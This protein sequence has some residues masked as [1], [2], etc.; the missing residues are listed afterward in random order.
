MRIRKSFYTSLVITA[1]FSAVGLSLESPV[2]TNPL[3]LGTV[4][5]TAYKSGLVPSINPIDT[6]G[7]QVVTGNVVGGMYFRGVV[8]YRGVTDFSAPA[9][10]LSHTSA[11]IDPFLRNSAASADLSRPGGGIT[12]FYSPSWTVSTTAGGTNAT[13]TPQAV[14]NIPI[15]S[16][17]GV[18]PQGQSVYNQAGYIP[19]MSSRPLSMSRAEMEK[20]L[21]ADAVKYPLGAEPVSEA[22]SQRQFWQQLKIPI[23]RRQETP[24]NPDG[25]SKQSEPNVGALLNFKTE[26]IKPQDTQPADNN[27]IT[28]QQPDVYEQMKT[29][30]ENPLTNTKGMIEKTGL[31]AKGL[32]ESN[33]QSA[34][35]TS[36]SGPP[37]IGQVGYGG[38]YKSFAAFSDDKFNQY[39]SSA[40]SY[41][42][43]GRYYRAADAYTMAAV[44]KPKDPLGYAGKSQALFA[45]GEYMSSSLFLARALEIFPDYAKAKIDLV[46]M[47]GDKDTIENR[48]LEAREWR[49]RSQS[50]ELEFLLSYVYCQ[51]DR[52]EFARQMIESATKK[53]PDSPAVA[54][55]KKAVDERIAKQ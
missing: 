19:Q 29:Q 6:S 32:A 53:L 4:P 8:P 44:Y 49:E 24:T 23:D 51:M 48:I 20:A 35:G 10:S 34:T 18:T 26:L 40:E 15:T 54:A 9:S 45:A 42:K 50:G 33:E 36:K 16:Y 31:T 52:M 28:G 5:P 11:G 55:M 46:G 13:L 7:N 38:I 41:M 27:R 1:V 12:P 25:S 47:I 39:I 3:G 21:E 30:L 2:D 43:Q 17:S 37:M 22:Q 14:G